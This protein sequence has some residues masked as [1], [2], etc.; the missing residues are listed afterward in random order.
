MREKVRQEEQ[1]QRRQEAERQRENEQRLIRERI[2]MQR[3]REAAEREARRHKMPHIQVKL[4]WEFRAH[5]TMTIV[6]S[7]VN[8]G[9]SSELVHRYLSIG[10]M[11]VEWWNLVDTLII[12]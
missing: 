11:N 1:R 10:E 6:S 12:H 7:L 4:V 3:E 2:R 8:F 5:M 9:L